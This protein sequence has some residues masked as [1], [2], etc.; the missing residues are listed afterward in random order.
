MF[1]FL[2]GLCN[3]CFSSF[4]HLFCSTSTNFFLLVG[5]LDLPAMVEVTAAKETM[6]E[7]ADAKFQNDMAQRT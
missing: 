6:V 2:Q 5:W 3:S 7:E 1:L 4:Y